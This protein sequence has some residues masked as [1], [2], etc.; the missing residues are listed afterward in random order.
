MNWKAWLDQIFDNDAP[1]TPRTPGVDPDSLPPDWRD[2][3]E[4]RAAIM[5][6]EGGLHREQA[7]HFALQETLKLMRS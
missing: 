3:Y 2:C 4:E 7:E 1:I 6:Y 5:E